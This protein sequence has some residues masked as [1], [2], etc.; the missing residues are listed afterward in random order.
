MVIDA[1]RKAQLERV[2][3]D[4][5]AQEAAE[6]VPPPIPETAAWVQ[7]ISTVG[8]YDSGVKVTHGGKTWESTTRHNV[9]QPGV[10]GW[11]EVVEAGSG[12]AAWVQPTGGHD[13]YRLDA[14]VAHKGQTWRNTGSDANVWEP[15]V[16]G[17]TVVT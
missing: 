15:G 1:A 17:W 5:I 8:M 9:W 7:P 11:R 6:V 3:L 16:F 14:V 4:L 13:A 10:S 12:P 2:A